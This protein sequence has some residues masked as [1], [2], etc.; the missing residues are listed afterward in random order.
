MKILI[1]SGFEAH[2]R[3]FTAGFGFKSGDL[4][5]FYGIFPAFCVISN[6]ESLMTLRDYMKTLAASISLARNKSQSR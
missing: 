1:F 4:E 2:S 5:S 3:D 6:L